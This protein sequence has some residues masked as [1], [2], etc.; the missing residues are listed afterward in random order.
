MHIE[1]VAS[2][3]PELLSAFARLIPQLTNAPIPT[4]DELQALIDSSSRLIVARFPART[5]RL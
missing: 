3:T 2:I 4:R 1:I 5:A